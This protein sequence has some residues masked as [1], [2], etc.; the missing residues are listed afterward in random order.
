MGQAR[1]KAEAKAEVD[2]LTKLQQLWSGLQASS[3]EDALP[4]L[5]QEIFQQPPPGLGGLAYDAVRAL[6]RGG[7]RAVPN[8]DV[9]GDFLASLVTPIYRV[10]RREI[11]LRAKPSAQYGSAALSERVMYDDVNEFFWS[12]A[13]V[14]RLLD[15]TTSR[16]V[17][18]YAGLR[19]AFSNGRKLREELRKRKTEF[20]NTLAESK[21]VKGVIETIADERRTASSTGVE[22]NGSTN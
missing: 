17:A 13:N 11:L 12:R 15:G 4:G 20:E 22:S 21:R 19:A 9:L 14:D 8:A 7:M 18:A 2:V 16:P 5:P 3:F 6:A 10:L 1:A